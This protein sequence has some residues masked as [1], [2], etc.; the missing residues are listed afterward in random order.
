M[1]I[2][3]LTTIMLSLASS[4]SN[5]E[6]SQKC[7][8]AFEYKQ[9]KGSQN[10][11]MNLDEAK[12]QLSDTNT[13]QFFDVLSSEEIQALDDMKIEFEDLSKRHSFTKDCKINNFEDF[14]QSANNDQ[15]T[16]ERIAPI[17]QRLCINLSSMSG[18]TVENHNT[19]LVDKKRTYDVRH[20]HVDDKK[21]DAQKWF[22]VIVNLQGAGTLFAKFN[23]SKSLEFVQSCSGENQNMVARDDV[24]QLKPGQAVVFDHATALH[25]RPE[26][27][28]P[29][30]LMVIDF[31]SKDRT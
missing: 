21:G 7:N 18:A 29:R 15:Q 22:R 1:K 8:K 9:N 19:I 3:A 27:I 30:A 6:I 13:F 24:W 20:W 17:L 28:A 26:I 12:N 25:S 14:L 10:F 5:L 23:S 11:E 4:N 16:Q 2:L 31:K